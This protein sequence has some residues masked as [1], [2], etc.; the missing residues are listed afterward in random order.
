MNCSAWLDLGRIRL[1]GED[2]QTMT[3]YGVLL[4]LV[5]IVVIAAVV[6]LGP[7]IY[8]IFTSVASQI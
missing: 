5:A 8:S 4:A 7:P 2:G 1:R 3:E 6:L